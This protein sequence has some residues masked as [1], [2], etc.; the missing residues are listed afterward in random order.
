MQH[1][2]VSS[3][4][5]QASQP[6]DWLNFRRDPFGPIKSIKALT[7]NR[8]EWCLWPADIKRVTDSRGVGLGMTVVEW[9]NQNL[10][11]IMLKKTIRAHLTYLTEPS[12][13]KSHLF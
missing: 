11:L 7:G 4:F 9:L 6:H 13:T 12:T 10:K 2:Q 8:I 3:R 1:L 5:Q